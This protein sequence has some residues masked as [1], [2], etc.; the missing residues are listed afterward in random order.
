MLS[1]VVRSLG[2]DAPMKP[3]HVHHPCTKWV[4][5]TSSNFEWLLL[6]CEEIFREYTRRYHKI[7]ATE[8]KLH[9]I[10][11]QKVR[12]KE[13]PLTPFAQAIRFP[14]L[15]GPDP[16]VSYRLYYVVD[17]VR[18]AKWAHGPTPKW[19]TDF[20]STGRLI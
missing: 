4:G 18:F 20:W 6:H 13:G 14:D 15:I 16:V 7:H 12:P 1:T 19:W 8:H 2:H 10:R 17:K 5:E 11:D 3:T 9:W